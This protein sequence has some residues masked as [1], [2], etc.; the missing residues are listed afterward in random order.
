MKKKKINKEKP[1]QDNQKNVKMQKDT[2]T[3]NEVD[4]NFE[5]K[6]QISAE[7]Q[8]QKELKEEKEKYLRLYAEFE[9]YRKRTAKERLELFETAGEGVIKNLLPILDDFDRALAEMKKNHEDELAKGVELIFDKLKNTLTKEGLKEVVVKKEDDF[10]PE[11][12][13]AIAQVPAP[14]KKMVGKIVDVIEKGYQLGNK[15][16]RFPKVVTGK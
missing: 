1:L 7:A 9:N 3:Q 11:F 6:E 16:I 10:N 4:A 5:E 12:Q 14:S 8:L 15:I 13:E 2:N